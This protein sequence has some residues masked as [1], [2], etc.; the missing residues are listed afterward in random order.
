MNLKTI[1]GFFVQYRTAKASRPIVK[2]LPEPIDWLI[3]AVAIS[4]LVTILG[5]AIYHYPHLPE[6]IPSHF[7]GSGEP[8]DFGPKSTFWLLPGLSVFIY[9]MLSLIMLIPQ[10]FNYT[11]KITPRNALKQYTYAMRLVRYVKAVIIWLF[12]Y[13]CSSTV[14]VSAG[15]ESGLGLWFLP[16]FLSVLFIP[17][18]LYFILSFR[19]R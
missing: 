9:I 19:K 5:Y 7:N 13:I 12:F 4:G 17:M 10:Q 2:P 14:R 11:V 6:M 15:K 3:E 8:D 18:I 16:V 1:G